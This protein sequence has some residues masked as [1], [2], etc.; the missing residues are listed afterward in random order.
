MPFGV[1]KKTGRPGPE[2]K[3]F[4][5]GDKCQ[6]RHRVNQEVSCGAMPDPN[7]LPCTECDHIGEDRR[8]EYHHH[9]GY[10]VEYF[11]HVQPLCTVCHPAKDNAKKQQTC[12]LHG[13]EYTSENTIIK[14]NGTRE[15]RACRRERDRKRRGPAWWR[16]YRKNRKE[17]SHGSIH[18]D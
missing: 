16:E 1:N 15:C 2:P 4:V 10:S 7:T 6:A 8:H 9:L 13:H 14:A 17:A 18:Q 5:D 12:C 3:P 11:L